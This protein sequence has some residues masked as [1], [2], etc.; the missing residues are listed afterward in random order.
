MNIYSPASRILCIYLSFAAI[1][2]QHVI[3]LLGCEHSKWMIP[4]MLSTGILS[5]VFLLQ[6]KFLLED[7]FQLK[8]LVFA[9]YA[10]IIAYSLLVLISCLSIVLPS[11]Y[12]YNTGFLS[13]IV[14]IVIFAGYISFYRFFIRSIIVLSG[15]RS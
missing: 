7:Q 11:G 8:G 1:V 10:I 12:E 9:F 2:A 3:N 6:F 4:F 14:S 13:Y 15:I 5:A